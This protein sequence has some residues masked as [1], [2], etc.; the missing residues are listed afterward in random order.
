[1]RVELPRHVSYCGRCEGAGVVRLGVAL[2]VCGVCK[3]TGIV[4]NWCRALAESG[5]RE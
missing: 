3:G 2:L 1:M 4:V 5:V